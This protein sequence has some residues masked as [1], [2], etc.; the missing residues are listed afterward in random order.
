MTVWQ[1]LFVPT[2]AFGYGVTPA[3]FV[4][5][6]GRW[7]RRP[8]PRI[9]TSIFSEVGFFLSAASAAMAVSSLLYAHVIHFDEGHTDDFLLNMVQCGV[10]IWFIGILLG[11]IGVWRQNPLRWHAPICGIGTLALWMQFLYFPIVG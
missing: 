7:R 3:M 1:T 10:L 9:F 4:W 8:K 5:G 11:L 2:A 6:W